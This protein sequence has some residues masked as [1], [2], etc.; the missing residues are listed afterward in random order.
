[1]LEK[2][3]SQ[4][5]FD[6]CKKQF[7]VDIEQVAKID[8][9]QKYYTSSI[10]I[11]FKNRNKTILIYSDREFLTNIAQILLFEDAPD[12]ECLIDLNNEIA[13]LVIGHSK[14][15]AADDGYPYKIATPVYDG[16]SSVIEPTLFFESSKGNMIIGLND[17]R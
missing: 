6:V 1:M 9:T 13:N 8:D 2:Y 15:L 16:Q 14:V 12:E 5:V 11:V 4:A 17:G 10:D 7:D 3:I